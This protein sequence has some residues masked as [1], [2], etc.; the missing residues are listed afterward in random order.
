MSIKTIPLVAAV[1]AMTLVAACDPYGPNGNQNARTGALIGAGLGAAAAGI[2]NPDDNTVRERNQRILLGAAAGAAGGAVIGN[3]LDRQ[4]EELR[5]QLGNNIGV[6][7][8][9]DQLVVTMPNDILFATDSTAVSA[10]LRSDLSIVANSL[11]RYPNTTV[12]VVGHTDNVGAASYNYDLSTRRAQAV[13]QILAVNGVSQSRLRTV[14]R[15][16]DQPI[17]TNLTAEGRQQ[18]RRV[19]IIITP[20]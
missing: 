6:V 14:G 18:N 10:A 11:N 12:N 9:G 16:E 17:A 7:N 15:G 2:T 4:A 19:E 1:S 13:A 20:M 5:A 8:T 3:Q